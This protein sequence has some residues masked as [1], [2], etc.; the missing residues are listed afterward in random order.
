[1]L[2]K[3]IKIYYIYNIERKCQLKRIFE[4]MKMQLK[5]NNNTNLRKPEMKQQ[6]FEK[7]KDYI[8]FYNNYNIL[9]YSIYNA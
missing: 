2:E 6:K 4:V 3:D 5:A 8:L 7:V 9:Y 1:M